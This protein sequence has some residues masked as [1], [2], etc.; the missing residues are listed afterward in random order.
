MHQPM[1]FGVIVA[2]L[3][4]FSTIVAKAFSSV[5]ATTMTP[6]TVMVPANAAGFGPSSLLRKRDSGTKV[7]KSIDEAGDADRMLWEWRH[8]GKPWADITRKWTELTGKTPGKSTLSVRF[9][10]L[11]DNFALTGGADVGH[12]YLWCSCSQKA[13]IT[14][15]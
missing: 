7:P 3:L 9:I 11:Q 1:R 4:P 5:E 10:K 8:A 6:Q 13:L 14:V 2:S 12:L 15:I